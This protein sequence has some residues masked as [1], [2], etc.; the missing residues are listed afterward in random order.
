MICYGLA[1]LRAGQSPLRTPDPP[2]CLQSSY[3]KL[4]KRHFLFP[5]FSISCALFCSKL[6][7]N[8]FA[9]SSFRTLCRKHRG[10]Y[11]P[12]ESPHVFKCLRTLTRS[13]LWEGFV[14]PFPQTSRGAK[15]ERPFATLPSASRWG[16]V[17]FQ[18]ETHSIPFLFI[19]LSEFFLLNERGYTLP[20]L[21][22]PRKGS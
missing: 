17:V 8:S 5:L 2:S 7:Y 11:T 14:Y 12:Q 20:P 9:I 10:G 13:G 22:E 4:A 18:R 6:F 15:S 21:I 3:P 19:P 16:S 1:V